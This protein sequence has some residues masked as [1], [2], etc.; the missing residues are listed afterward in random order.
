M[1]PQLSILVPVYNEA[2]TVER[3]IDALLAAEL[4]FS[5]EL[6]I[7]DDG[8]TDGSGRILDEGDWP[9]DRVRVFHHDGNQGKGTAVR[10]ALEHATGEFASIFDAD[11]E[12]DPEDL[13][14]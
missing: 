5:T 4:P 11:L 2:A 8:S 9:A 1:A 6:I 14:V 7:V 12:Y 10:T 3:A 13:V